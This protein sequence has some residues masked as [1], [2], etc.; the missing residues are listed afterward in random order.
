MTEIIKNGVI[1]LYKNYAGQLNACKYTEMTVRLH[2]DVLHWKICVVKYKIRLLWIFW[3]PQQIY[4][5]I[6]Y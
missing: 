2:F 4:K 3:L 5:H 6:N 1:S